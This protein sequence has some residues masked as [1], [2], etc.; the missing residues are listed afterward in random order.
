MS[1]PGKL[2][3]RP[4]D[5]SKPRVKMAG[6]FNLSVTEP[7]YAAA[8]T[9][10][11]TP[12]PMDHNDTVGDCVVAGT[13]HALRA[14]S[15]LLTGTAAGLTDPQM[16]AMYQSQNPGFTSW[17]DAGSPD[18]NGMDIQT[19]LEWCVKQGWILAFG[20]LDPTD[21][22][23]MK[24]AT[25]IGLAV[26]TGETLQEA[27][28]QQT[29]WTPVNGSPVAGGHCTT[30]VGYDGTPDYFDQATWGTV[31]KMTQAFVDTQMSEAWFVLTEDHVNHPGFRD[32]FDLEGFAA[33]VST[34]TDGKVIVP[35]TPKPTPTPTP[36]PSPV[37]DAADKT[38]WS[39]I[40]PWTTEHH[41][42]AN[43]KTA[44]A[45]TAWAAA[46]GL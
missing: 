30:I 10:P 27:Q 32:N 20:E 18:D 38:L 36:T 31:L 29:I 24:A 17:S 46:K 22:Q 1:F 15:F 14:I 25:W 37:A 2:G 6:F 35:V 34:V 41:I 23:Q 42:G 11:N 8:D 9:V 19:A 5:P 3:L 4:N 44:E 43:H 12:L 16:L 26:I 7:V 21:E 45:L 13:D 39:K 33:A 40:E 28:E